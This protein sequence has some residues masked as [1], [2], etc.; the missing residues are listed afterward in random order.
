VRFSASTLLAAPFSVFLRTLKVF[1]SFSMRLPLLLSKTVAHLLLFFF[2]SY[3]SSFLP[4]WSLYFSACWVVV[5]LSR[6]SFS[7]RWRSLCLF[8]FFPLPRGVRRALT[9]L[10]HPPKSPSPAFSLYLLLDLT[11]LFPFPCRQSLR[12]FLPVFRFLLSSPLLNEPNTAPLLLSD[13]PSPSFLSLPLYNSSLSSFVR[14]G[15]CT[16]SPYVPLQE[17]RPLLPLSC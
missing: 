1:A 14:P 11:F 4:P 15:T 8:P 16:S 6:A 12:A 13:Y 17:I 7:N 9:F 2:L 10:F 5:N 3:L